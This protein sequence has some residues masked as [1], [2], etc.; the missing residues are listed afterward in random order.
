MKAKANAKC[1]ICGDA[2][3]VESAHIMPQAQGGKEAMPPMPQSPQS[4]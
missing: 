3:S 4:I 1:V 2:R